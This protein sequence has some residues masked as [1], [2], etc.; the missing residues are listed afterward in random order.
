MDAD[1]AIRERRPSPTAPAQRYVAAASGARGLAL[2]APGFFEYELAADGDL[3]LTL[4]RCV[5]Q[6]SRADLPPA[7]A[8]RAGPPPRP[9]P[10]ASAPTACSSRWRRLTAPSSRRE[11]ARRSCGKTCSSRP[12]RSGCA[13]R[14]RS[15]L[16]TS[17]V[18]ARGRRPRA[19]VGQAGRRR[20]ARAAL[21]QRDGRS[22]WTRRWRLGRPASRAEL[23]RAD[24]RGAAT[25]PLWPM[26]AARSR[27]APGPGI[28]TIGDR[29]PLTV[30]PRAERRRHGGLSRRPE[31]LIC[32]MHEYPVAAVL[33]LSPSL[34]L[35][36]LRRHP[37]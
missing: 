29:L 22:R 24:E 18:R 37:E 19:L 10:S 8:T 15:T 35:L 28:V 23:V 11:R 32:R 2:L 7:P 36:R 16:R 30:R 3:R 31:P 21:L 25:A 5:G 26:A 13:R 1:P 6:L 27:S 33:S 17:D 14:R 9:R 20:R 34:V 4:L 12:A